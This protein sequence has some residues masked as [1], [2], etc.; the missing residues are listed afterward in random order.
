M[1]ISSTNLFIIGSGPAGLTAAIYSARA[2]LKPI[3]C[4][5]TTPGGQLIGTTAVENWPGDISILGPELMNRMREH[6]AYYGAQFVEG[7]VIKVDFNQ[8]PFH[9]STNTQF[10]F[11][12]QALIIATGATPRRLN[13]PG[14][15]QY[16]G[17]GVSTCAV[18]DGAL[19]KNKSVIVVGGGDSALEY[20]SFLAKFTN[21]ITIIHIKDAL[22]ASAPLQQRVLSNTT[23]TIRYSSSVAEIVGDGKRVTHVIVNNNIT[24][25]SESLPT[26]GIF[27]AIGLTP[28]SLLVKDQVSC[29]PAGYII[30]EPHSTRTSIEGVFVAG[31]CADARYRQAVTSAGDGCRA[32][33]DA[34][35][36]LS[37][38]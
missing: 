1:P 2:E 28:N 37:E 29:D 31:D 25:A 33:L 24:D 7:S 8:R 15:S 30:Q 17:K 20:A 35:R 10:Q 14:E 38:R 19:Y 6:A 26:E 32:A 36:F 12:A 9:I 27:I 16:W 5:G 13:C 23:I 3:V 22:T 11:E 21:K 4:E 18:C 34:E